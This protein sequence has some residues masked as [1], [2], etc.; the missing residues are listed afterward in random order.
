MNVLRP[1]LEHASYLIQ[2]C[3]TFDVAGLVIWFVGSLLLAR[4]R[5]SGQIRSFIIAGSRTYR[6]TLRIPG[7]T[8]A[9]KNERWY[10]SVVFFLY[11]FL[12]LP[13]IPNRSGGASAPYHLVLHV[14]MGHVRFVRLS[15]PQA[16]ENREKCRRVFFFSPVFFFPFAVGD[17]TMTEDT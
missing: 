14:H 6:S 3:R 11:F 2:K 7:A 16:G 1:M 5:N 8:A 9:V 15:R 4:V 12:P 17:E 13:P 10:V